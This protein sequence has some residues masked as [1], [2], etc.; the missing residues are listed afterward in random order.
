MLGLETFGPKSFEPRKNLVSIKISCPKKFW[1]KK[2]FESKKICV[3]KNLCSKKF[4]VQKNTQVKQ[5]KGSEKN[6]GP[7]RFW[8]QKSF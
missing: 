5:N 8:V 1:V 7:K 3:Q 2:H 4:C 6:L